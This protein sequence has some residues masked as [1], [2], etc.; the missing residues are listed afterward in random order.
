[1]LVQARFVEQPGEIADQVMIDRGLRHSRSRQCRRRL[2]VR[3][4]P[5]AMYHEL[6]KP[7]PDQPFAAT[8][9]IAARPVMASAYPSIPNPHSDAVATGATNDRWRKLSR[10]KTWE[11]CTSITGTDMAA[12][13]SWMATDVCV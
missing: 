5:D 1:D 7:A 4:S 6:R 9:T 10:A 3:T 8:P 12:M 2:D 13:A 11:M